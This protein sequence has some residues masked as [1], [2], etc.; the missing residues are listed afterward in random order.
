MHEGSILNEKHEKPIQDERK[1]EFVFVVYF[2]LTIRFI[3]VY[4]FTAKSNVK[5]KCYM[6]RQNTIPLS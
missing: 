5:F 3:S 1:G 4:I 6:P 2:I